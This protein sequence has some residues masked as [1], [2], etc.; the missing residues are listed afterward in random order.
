M[1]IT[2]SK[3]QWEMVGQKAGWMKIANIPESPIPALQNEKIH[4][5]QVEKWA[6]QLDDTKLYYYLVS[7]VGR[8]T[9]PEVNELNSAMKGDKNALMALKNKAYNSMGA[10]TAYI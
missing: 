1:K 5:P 9:E 7:V 3:S 10:K 4:D 2:L 6:R 8:M